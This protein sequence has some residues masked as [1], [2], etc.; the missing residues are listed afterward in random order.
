MEKEFFLRTE[1]LWEAAEEAKKREIE[2][3]LEETKDL[4][5]EFGTF[6]PLAAHG[7]NTGI[8][9][10]E[11]RAGIY[12]NSFYNALKNGRMTMETLIK[13]SRYSKVS[14]DYLVGLSDEKF[15]R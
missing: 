12:H 5:K 9:S 2:D 10:L 4:P 8:S 7:K 13:I 15:L 6:K 14:I 3:E 11:R 1:R